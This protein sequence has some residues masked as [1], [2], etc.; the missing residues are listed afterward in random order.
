VLRAAGAKIR[1]FNARERRQRDDQLGR[2]RTCDAH[3]RRRWCAAGVQV[4]SLTV[5]STDL[6]PVS[7]IVQSTWCEIEAALYAAGSRLGRT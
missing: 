2:R 6:L 3:R 7:E 4:S 5:E 1:R